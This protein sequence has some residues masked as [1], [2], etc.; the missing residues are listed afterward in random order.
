MASSCV[1]GWDVLIT[2]GR[3]PETSTSVLKVLNLYFRI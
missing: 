2:S 1:L 3:V